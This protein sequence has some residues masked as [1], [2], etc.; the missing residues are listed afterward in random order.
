M[1][2]VKPQRH[3]DPN[4]KLV[5]LIDIKSKRLYELLL[6]IMNTIPSVEAMK[7]IDSLTELKQQ[8]GKL[9]IDEVEQIVT[10]I[11]KKLQ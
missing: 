3:F 2:E 9:D 10:E 6:E 5:Q 4:N 11:K 8:I 7:P 1:R